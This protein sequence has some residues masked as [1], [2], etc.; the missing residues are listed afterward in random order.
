[1]AYGTG[2]TGYTSAARAKLVIREFF[3]RPIESQTSAVFAS[4]WSSRSNISGVEL[5]YIIGGGEA[6]SADGWWSYLRRLHGST[7]NTSTRSAG[8][9]LGLPST[10]WLQFVSDRATLAALSTHVSGTTDADHGRRVYEFLVSTAIN[11]S[12][13]HYGIY[14][15]LLEAWAGRGTSDVGSS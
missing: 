11:S 6:N 9:I 14:R 12:K 4:I 15:E 13:Y 8:G 2:S 1:M 7:Y 5:P 3:A 10:T